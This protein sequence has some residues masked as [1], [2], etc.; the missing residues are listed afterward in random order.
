MSMWLPQAP[1][2]LKCPICG[3]F[4]DPSTKPPHNR[5]LVAHM[6][7]AHPFENL[8]IKKP[9]KTKSK[10]SHESSRLFLPNTAKRR[11]SSTN[12]VP[13]QGG[14]RQG[15]PKRTHSWLWRHK[16]ASEFQKVPKKKRYQ[17]L[18]RN[19]IPK[20]DIYRWVADLKSNEFD[21][22]SNLRKR[23]R[24]TTGKGKFPEGENDLNDWYVKRRSEGYRVSYKLLKIKMRSIMINRDDPDFDPTIHKFEQNWCIGFCKRKNISLQRKTNS[25][26]R[27]IYEKLHRI[28]SYHT[29]LI[30][31]MADPKNDYPALTNNGYDKPD[32]EA[33][34]ADDGLNFESEGS[35]ED[36]SSEI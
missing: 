1:S 33:D 18:Q 3:K 22:A 7:A 20:S 8:P 11:R 17:W 5:P 9:P 34:F 14:R 19:Q 16:K 35:S 21:T 32:Y 12:K 25:K 2:R 26:S 30:Y 4:F 23:V 15:V 36:E 29:W 6:A 31:M 10:P 28:S 27:S 13:G 24:R